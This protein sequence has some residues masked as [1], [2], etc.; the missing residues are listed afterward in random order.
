MA[1]VLHRLVIA[2][3]IIM[4]L[5]WPR[6]AEAERR[7]ALVIG[8]AAYAHAPPLANP[9]RDAGDVA[10]ALKR[11]GFEV[12]LGLDLTQGQTVKQIDAF[13]KAM[14]GADA[15]LLYYSGHG[16][17]IEGG[18]YLL[19]VDIE[20]ES[21]RSVRYG[22][23][24][25]GEIVRD[26]ER[27]AGVALVVLDACRDNPFAQK[28]AAEAGTRSATVSRGLARVKAA[29][30]GTIIAYAA[31]AGEVASDGGGGNSPYTKAFLELVEK[32][33]VEVGLLFRRVARANALRAARVSWLRRLRQLT[34]SGCFLGLLFSTRLALLLPA[35]HH[36]PTA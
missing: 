4:G 20:V 2:G 25:V 22:A 8:N 30:S 19:P 33:N 18:N 5:A 32:P 15:A 12:Q 17:Q 31:A 16:L 26:M 34:C 36:T 13:A 28:L 21:E 1:R 6:A 24:D 27:S 7:V 3:A 10:A 35:V 9:G 29:G 11:L 23:V 14:V